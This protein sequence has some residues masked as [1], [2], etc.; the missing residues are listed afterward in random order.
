MNSDYRPNYSNRKKKSVSLTRKKKMILT[1]LLVGTIGISA[2]YGTVEGVKDIA[3]NISDSY[4]Y[5]KDSKIFYEMVTQNMRAIPGT[6]TLFLDTYELA[7]DFKKLD[8][9]SKEEVYHN[10]LGCARFMQY[11]LDK[12]FRDFVRVLDLDQMS[13]LNPIYPTTQELFNY[14]EK[15]G[16]I[17]ED[18]TIDF[19]KWREYDKTI[20]NL[21][22]E[23]EDYREG[24]NL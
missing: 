23:L 18:G 16:F 22:R 24:K 11:N 12:N 21:E 3:N 19:E 17:K 10:L 15:L 8:L 6:T 14:I 20:F 2:V 7:D 13:R 1:W 4:H 9:E 5:N